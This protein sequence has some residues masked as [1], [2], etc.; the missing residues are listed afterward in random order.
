MHTGSVAMGLL[1]RETVLE[2]MDLDM[3]GNLVWM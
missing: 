2:S 3:V 1:T